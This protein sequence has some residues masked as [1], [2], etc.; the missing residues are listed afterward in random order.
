MKVVR[1]RVQGVVWERPT[2][3]DPVAL[4]VVSNNET[5]SSVVLTVQ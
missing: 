5:A 1:E 4:S 2:V 3:C